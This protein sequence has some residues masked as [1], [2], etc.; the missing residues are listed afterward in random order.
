MTI[1]YPHQEHFY[2]LLISNEGS[3]YQVKTHNSRF[4]MEDA[5]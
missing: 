4:Q 1:I 5:I 3:N 2:V